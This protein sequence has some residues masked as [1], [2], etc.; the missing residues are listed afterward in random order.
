MPEEDSTSGALRGSEP[1]ELRVENVE[2]S[3][4]TRR[5]TLIT[6]DVVRALLALSALAIFAVTLWAGFAGARSS[7]WAN[8]KELLDIV[9]PV[10]SLLLGG[11][12]GFSSGSRSRG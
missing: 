6:E 3:P 11:A 10:E 9:I 4:Q 2:P 12:V 1:A 5:V 7:N 8:T